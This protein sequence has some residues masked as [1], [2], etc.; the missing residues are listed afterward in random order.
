[1]KQRKYPNLLCFLEEKTAGMKNSIALG[2][3]T[4]VGWKELT[5]GGISYL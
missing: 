5:L 1:M 4:K 3:N 2:L